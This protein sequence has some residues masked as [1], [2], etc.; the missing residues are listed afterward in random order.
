MNL[1]FS[2]RF[3][4]DSASIGKIFSAG[5]L[6][7]VIGFLL[8]PAIAKKIGLVKTV[9]FSQFASIP[10]FA[11]LAFNYN[12]MPVMVAFWFRGSL[13]NMSSPLYSNFA[14]ESSPPEQHTGTNSLMMLSWNSAWMVSTFIGGKIIEHHGF[15][16]VM[17]ITI[18]LYLCTSILTYK[19]FKSSLGLG[20]SAKTGSSEIKTKIVA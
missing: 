6:F 2:N 16:P 12:L 19:F 7:T 13:M 9:S 3:G 10:F 11:I 8:G 20:I 17:L 1:Y 4:L 18:G 15:E 14:M 5:Q